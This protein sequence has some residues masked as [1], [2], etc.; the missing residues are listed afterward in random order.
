MNLEAR[1]G[2]S[3]AF[4]ARLCYRV[5]LCLKA[6]KHADTIPAEVKPPLAHGL[7]KA[8][9]CVEANLHPTQASR[10]ETCWPLNGPV[11]WKVSQSHFR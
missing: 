11:T 1:L 7:R 3:I 8:L 5:R 2:Y 10:A 6:N 9:W 4:Q